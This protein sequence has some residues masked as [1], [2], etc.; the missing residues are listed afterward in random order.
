[1]FFQNDFFHE[2][3][4][5]R[6]EEKRGSMLYNNPWRRAVKQTTLITSRINYDSF[7]TLQTQIF[8]GGQIKL[9]G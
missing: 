2:Q 7:Q 3:G 6:S 9:A 8:T 1:M 5:V 4:G